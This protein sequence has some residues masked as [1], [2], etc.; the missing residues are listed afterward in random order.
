MSR[1]VCLKGEE[2]EEMYNEQQEKLLQ[3]TRKLISFFEKKTDFPI[4]AMQK[5]HNLNLI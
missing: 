5:F 2:E 1:W 3:N 4:I